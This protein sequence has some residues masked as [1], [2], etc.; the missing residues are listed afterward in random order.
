MVKMVSF[1]LHVFYHNK[2]L[3]TVVSKVCYSLLFPSGKLNTRSIS[4]LPY[5]RNCREINLMFQAIPPWFKEMKE[6]KQLV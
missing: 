3:L 1:M 2:I 5:A 6:K 4:M